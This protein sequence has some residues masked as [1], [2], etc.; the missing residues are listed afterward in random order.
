MRSL[1]NTE[2]R[3]HYVLRLC[4]KRKYLHGGVFRRFLLDRER[5]LLQQLLVSARLVDG[6]APIWRIVGTI[7]SG[8]TRAKLTRYTLGKL[9]VSRRLS[10]VS[11]ISQTLAD[12]GNEISLPCPFPFLIACYV[13][14]AEYPKD[15]IV[16]IVN[17]NILDVFVG[18]LCI[19]L[20]F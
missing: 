7:A 12:N 14:P 16:S 9:G 8:N 20:K 15:L 10:G 2:K 4:A 18:C 5:A 19:F 11:G 13:L 6:S 1:R 3:A 17:N